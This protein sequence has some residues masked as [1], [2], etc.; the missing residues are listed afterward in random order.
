M[1]EELFHSGKD[2]RESGRTN[3]TNDTQPDLIQHQH[4][5]APEGGDNRTASHDPSLEEMLR[6]ALDSG[7]DDTPLP[8]EPY[9]RLK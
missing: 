8:G 1:E 4:G 2:E 5:P 7:M 6:R 9:V 3:E